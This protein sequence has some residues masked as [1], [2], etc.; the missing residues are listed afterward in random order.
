[1]W[2][3]S[4]WGEQAVQWQTQCNGITPNKKGVY[5]QIN[6]HSIHI[7]HILCLRNRQWTLIMLNELAINTGADYAA[8]WWQCWHLQVQC[9]CHQV[10]PG[11][12]VSLHSLTWGCIGG[13][14]SPPP[15]LNTTFIYVDVK[16]IIN[17]LTVDIIV[18]R[19]WVITG[20]SVLP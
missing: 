4:K 1:M 5:Q 16:W 9:M 14:S 8:I 15:P 18:L 6:V 20:M 3:I 7:W 2:Q 10:H 19:H 17:K 13:V 12:S 11:C